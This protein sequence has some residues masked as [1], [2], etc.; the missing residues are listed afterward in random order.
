[1][2]L[3]LCSSV[4][5]HLFISHNDKYFYGITGTIIN[6][7]RA[8]FIRYS[9]LFILEEKLVIQNIKNEFGDKP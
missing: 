2:G 8:Y 6:G 7:H 4:F 5:Y 1:M 9:S 3:S